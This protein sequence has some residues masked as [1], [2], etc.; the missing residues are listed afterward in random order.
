MIVAKYGV[1]GGAIAARRLGEFGVSRIGQLWDACPAMYIKDE[2]APIYVRWAR[3]YAGN[4][5]DLTSLGDDIISIVRAAD[6]WSR[7]RQI[8]ESKKNG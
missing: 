1:D 5:D 2:S 6:A 7:E 4:G 3:R 8:E